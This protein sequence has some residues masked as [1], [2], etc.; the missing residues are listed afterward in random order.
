MTFLISKEDEET[1]ESIRSK[2]EELCFM[3][4]K[5]N[6]IIESKVFLSPPFMH[7]ILSLFF[8]YHSA[9]L[10]GVILP[11][12]ED[13]HLIRQNLHNGEIWHFEGR[14]ILIGDI[15]E[16]AVVYVKD[17]LYVSGKVQGKIYLEQKDSFI[18]AE[19][20]EHA[21]I[22]FLYDVTRYVVGKNQLWGQDTKGETT[23]RELSLLPAVKVE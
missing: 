8:D 2:I 14:T 5:M 10:K 9:I 23:W 6:V 3:K 21:Q 15:H 18:Y 7:R 19:E 20:M 17:M 1:L 4:R 11:K 13:I 12:K 16:D 22:I